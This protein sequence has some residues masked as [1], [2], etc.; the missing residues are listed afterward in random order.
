MIYINNLADILSRAQK[1]IDP[2][3]VVENNTLEH[4]QIISILNEVLA[5]IIDR[6]MRYRFHYF[7]SKG[8]AFRAVAEV[9]LEHAREKQ[10]HADRIVDRIKQLG[11]RTEMNLTIS[12]R[13]NHR[14]SKEGKSLAYMI[15]ESLI[16]DRNAIEAY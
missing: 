5:S 2:G 12:V 13:H 14:K 3:V 4:D 6:A 15:R 10:K 9:F 8:I 11:G 1:K 7:M 16:A